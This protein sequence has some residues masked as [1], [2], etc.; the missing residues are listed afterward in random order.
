MLCLDCF[1]GSYEGVL[2]LH[3]KGVVLSSLLV[4]KGENGFEL[5]ES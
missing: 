3:E 2:L 4:E 1:C 5:R